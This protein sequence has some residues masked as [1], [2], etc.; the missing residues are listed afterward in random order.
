[1]PIITPAY[2]AMNSTHNVNE[3][4]KRI[5]MQEF[6][7]GHKICS[8]LGQLSAGASS[9]PVW[10]ELAEKTDF[11]SRYNKYIRVDVVAAE[12]EGFRKWAGLAESQLRML[13]TSMCV[14]RRASWRA[15]WL[16]SPIASL[17]PA[18]LQLCA[19]HQPP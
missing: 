10:A 9:Q 8:R 7:R 5:L 14:R 12:Q 18:C 11:F 6:A 16:A 1:M 4:T 3:A 2:P 19:G 15:G 17:L 13:V